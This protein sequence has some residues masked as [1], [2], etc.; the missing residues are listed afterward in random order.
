[1]SLTKDEHAVEIAG[2]NVTVSGTTGAVHATWIL[3]ID[4]VEADRAAAAGDFTLRG[5]L[6]DGSAVLAA[7]HQSLLGPTKV[8]VSHGEDPVAEFDGFVA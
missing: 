1:M 6:P 5:S 8:T 4:G 2:S 3:A 7:V